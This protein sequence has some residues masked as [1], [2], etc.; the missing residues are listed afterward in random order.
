MVVDRQQQRLQ[1]DGFGEGAF[2]H[3][4]GR[5]GEVD[6]AFGVALDVAGEAVVGQPRGRRV[7]H[8]AG[9]GEELHVV[10]VEAEVGQ[11]VEGATDAGHHPV[12]ASLGQTPGEQF[13]HAAAISRSRS[14]GGLHHGEFVMVGQQRSGHAGTVQSRTACQNGGH[15]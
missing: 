7:V 5:A 8:D 2:D 6:L 1:N 12:A 9:A 13:E 4:Q 11:G 3:Q 15:D 10:T 14:E